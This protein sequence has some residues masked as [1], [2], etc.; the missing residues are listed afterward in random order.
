LFGNN[1]GSLFADPEREKLFT[2]RMLKA[3][4]VVSGMPGYLVL[5]MVVLCK[6]FREDKV[7]QS[8]L[9]VTQV[10]R[11]NASDLLPGGK[12]IFLSWTGR[13]MTRLGLRGTNPITHFRNDWYSPG[14]L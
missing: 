8:K 13:Y 10:I 1:S 12:L 7:R 2:A 3:A 14:L 6:L 11:K 9:S 5:A 4:S